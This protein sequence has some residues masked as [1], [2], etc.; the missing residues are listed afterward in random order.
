[1]GSSFFIIAAGA[2]GL[3]D[4]MMR[5]DDPLHPPKKAGPTTH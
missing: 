1:M 2:A 3:V 5:C 4:I